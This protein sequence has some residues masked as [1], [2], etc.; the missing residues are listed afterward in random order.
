[1]IRGLIIRD[2]W[3]D[4]ILSGRKSWELRGSSTSI[5]GRIA[6]IRSGSGQVVGFCDL[7]GVVGPLTLQ[8]LRGWIQKHRV[9][10]S[11]LKGRPPYKKTFAWVL[12]NARRL[13]LPVPYTHPSGAVI[14]VRLLGIEDPT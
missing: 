13:R 8:D 14:W 3:I 12:E 10:N 4:E 9:P 2:P 7:V 5:R 11:L 1:V 6:L